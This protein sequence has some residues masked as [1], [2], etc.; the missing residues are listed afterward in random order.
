MEGHDVFEG[1]VLCWPWW[2]IV[3]IFVINSQMLLF[4]LLYKCFFK[5][6]T[7]E[8]SWKLSNICSINFMSV[9]FLP[10]IDIRQ[11][12]FD[13]KRTDFY[14]S[15]TTPCLKQDMNDMIMHFPSLVYEGHFHFIPNGVQKN[16]R[17]NLLKYVYV[18][19]FNINRVFI[20]C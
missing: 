3:N 15:K 6:F 9:R 13:F 8:A 2:N 14:W 5:S 11:N 20:I 18:I 12:H 1:H 4:V 17:W 10:S 16:V 7:K 19:Y